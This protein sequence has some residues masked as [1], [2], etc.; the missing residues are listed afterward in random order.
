MKRVAALLGPLAFAACCA[1]VSPA[2]ALELDDLQ[3]QIED[4]RKK[5]D[6]SKRKLDQA[7]GKVSTDDEVDI[8]RKL[9]SGLLGAAPLVDN[10]VMQQYVNDIGYWIASQSGRDKLPWRFGVI[11]SAGINAFAAPGG[12]IVI[13]LGLFDLLENEAQLAG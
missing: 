2:S 4:V 13:T 1:W 7:R 10:P 12:Y 5:A 11:D 3:K 9:M 8:G 6:K